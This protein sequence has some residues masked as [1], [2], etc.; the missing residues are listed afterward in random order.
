MQLVHP[1]DTPRPKKQNG[2]FSL[3]QEKKDEECNYCQKCMRAIYS[4]TNS[5]CSA[6]QNVSA[7][8]LDAVGGRNRA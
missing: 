7:S 1:V 4:Y 5:V 8:L 2:A 3:L 6:V